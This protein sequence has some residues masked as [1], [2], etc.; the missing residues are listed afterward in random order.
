M[1][2]WIEQMMRAGGW[3]MY[4]L[5]AMS[6][7]SLTLIFERAWFWLST[8]RPSRLARFA[9][10]TRATDKADQDKAARAVRKDR[11]VY[12]VFVRS[13]LKAVPRAYDHARMEVIARDQIERARPRIERFSVTLS[14]IITAAPMLGILGT[15]TGIISSF[16]VLSGGQI[17]DPS[18]VAGGI[19]QALLTTALGLVIALMTLFPYMIY[20]AHADRCFAKLELLA[21]AIIAT[22]EP[23]AQAGID[24]SA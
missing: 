15:V 9:S 18:E 1:M 5:A 22:S 19:A 24:D 17:T 16:R 7:L 13:L 4:P 2:A 8:H 12:G 11:S 3:V 6:L 21:E 23:N 10:V 14:T 20:R